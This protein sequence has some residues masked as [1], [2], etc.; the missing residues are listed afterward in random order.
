[1]KSSKAV[2]GLIGGIGSGKSRVAAAF[3]ARGGRVIAGDELAHQALRQPAIRE[4]IVRRWG[5]QVLDEKGE[6]N[7]RRLGAVVFA[8]VGERCAL[9]A[10]VHPWI[11]ERIRAE[12]A[13][14][15]DDPAVSFVVLDAAILLEAGWNDVCDRLVY[16]EAPSS[17][18]L[19][20]VAEQRGWSA[21]ELQAR[22]EAQ[23]P[24]T[25]K[26]ARAD[27]VLVNSGTLAELTRRVDDLLRLW[28]LAVP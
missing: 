6:I 21:E 2:I 3:A 15:Q 23:L 25:A 9:E 13:R 28:G 17:V 12:V 14:A 20:R 18:R 1:M 11:R 7:R 24:L 27:H 10:L 22:E 19:R 16:V 5:R 4:Q 8:D 26:A